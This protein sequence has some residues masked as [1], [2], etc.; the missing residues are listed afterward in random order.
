MSSLRSFIEYANTIIVDGAAK[1]AGAVAAGADTIAAGSHSAASGVL[2][3][4]ATD[5]FFKQD[6]AELT[7]EDRQMLDAYASAYLQAQSSETIVLKGYASSEGELDYNTKLSD[8]RAR[9]VRDYLVKPGGVPT[10]RITPTGMG[11][12][13]EFSKSK[14]DLQSNRRVT[15]TP[16]PPKAAPPTD[17]KKPPQPSTTVSGAG[18][19]VPTSMRIV[20]DKVT[21]YP[22]QAQTFKAMGYY[23]D[24]D[25]EADLDFDVKWSTS[26]KAALSI[27][28]DSG[29][30][31]AHFTEGT[32]TKTITITAMY[33]HDAKVPPA[34][35]KVF[36]ASPN[37]FDPATKE[38][39][40]QAYRL[41]FEDGTAGAHDQ[42]RK[43]QDINPKQIPDLLN[44][45]QQGYSDGVR[46][47]ASARRDGY[48]DA[49]N[50]VDVS[51]LRQHV[52]S[53]QVWPR[54]TKLAVRRL[55]IKY[56]EGFEAGLKGLQDK[57]DFSTPSTP[58]PKMGRD[59]LTPEEHERQKQKDEAR[60][61]IEEWLDELNHHIVE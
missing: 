47:A 18:R 35:A 41:G 59:P 28:R 45:Y 54:A 23:S 58:G 11:Q 40:D 36:V 20:P 24:T 12:T 6:S 50:E 57:K 1:L 56:R 22:E 25:E 60:K 53:L 30:A 14:D 3:A 16:P 49:I 44:S 5:M 29:D 55:L 46:A 27:D 51:V 7:P 33:D 4:T 38:Q 43:V 13:S 37:A 34:T 21:L 61:Q 9:A 2:P 32:D 17:V 8:Q 52:Q 10:G 15:I 31:T 26:N 48:D 39:L 42:Q 19:P